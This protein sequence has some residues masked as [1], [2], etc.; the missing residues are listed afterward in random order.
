MS[1]QIRC[2]IW[3]NQHVG[4]WLCLVLFTAVSKGIYLCKKSF[5]ACIARLSLR[6]SK[7]K[8]GD[9]LLLSSINCVFGHAQLVR[10][11]CGCCVDSRGSEGTF[12]ELCIYP[13]VC[14]Y[15]M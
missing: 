12:W 14:V 2:C 9:K 8:G 6:Y 7:Q 4:P 13:G 3:L 10:C 15:F 11:T 1:Y 5:C